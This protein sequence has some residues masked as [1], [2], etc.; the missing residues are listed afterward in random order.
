MQEGLTNTLRHGVDTRCAE[1]TVAYRSEE[2]EIAVRDDGAATRH[3]AEAGHGLHGM[4][5]RVAVYGVELIARP[6]AGR[7]FDLLASVPLEPE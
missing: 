7:G 5:E 1:T 2:L 6:R 4:R 3:D